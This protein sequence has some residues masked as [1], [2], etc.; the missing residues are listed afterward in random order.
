MNSDF[1][2]LLQ[3]RKNM[4]GRLE[5]LSL[6]QLN[7]IPAGFN[8]SLIWNA[9]H[10]LVT[11]QLLVYKNSGLTP[12]VSAD[13]IAAYRKGTRPEAPMDAA[14]W[15]EVKS[16]LLSRVSE[17]WEAY[18]RGDFRAYTPYSTSFGYRIEDVD[19]ALRFNNIH[20]AMHLGNVISMSK[21][22]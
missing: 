18:E 8:N 5:G 13:W 14:S 7:A 16:Q 3:T 17:S 19:D 21:L 20:E 4:L 22:V 6:D 12:L 9:A 2:L 15:E 1:Q 11:Q 10:V